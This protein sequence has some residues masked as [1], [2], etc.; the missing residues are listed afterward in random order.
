MIT[1]LIIANWKMAIDADGI[2]AFKATWNSKPSIHGIL[3]LIHI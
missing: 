3:S 1:P 2:D